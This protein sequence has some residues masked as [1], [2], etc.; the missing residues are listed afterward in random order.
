MLKFI[1]VIYYM[2][3]EVNMIK[4]KNNNLKIILLCTMIITFS[5]LQHISSDNITNLEDPVSEKKDNLNHSDIDSIEQTNSD[6]T[7]YES[8][9]D[10][11]EGEEEQIS[12]SD[13]FELIEDNEISHV[14]D[15][16]LF[17]ND[18]EE[19]KSNDETNQE[20]IKNNYS[21]IVGDGSEASPF[22]VSTSD[23]LKNAITES[24]SPNDTKHIKF[25]ANIIEKQENIKISHNT[26]IDGGGFSLIRNYKN[27]DSTYLF[28]NTP[29][30]T[31]AFKNLT[32]GGN[33]VDTQRST[34]Y[35]IVRVDSND[36]TVIA[37][38]INY[39]SNYGAQPF[40]STSYLNNTKVI[41]KGSNYFHLTGE[42]IGEFAQNITHLV[43]SQDS[44]TII[45]NPTLDTGFDSS[46]FFYEL[47]SLEIEDNATL[48]IVTA[49]YYFI[50]LDVDVKSLQINIGQNSRLKI[51]M[52]HS[53]ITYFRSYELGHFNMNVGENA[54]FDISVSGSGLDY[55]N[56]TINSIDPYYIKIEHT[57]YKK[58]P[59][60]TDTNNVL[61]IINNSN[62]NANYFINMLKQGVQEESFIE[63]DQGSDGTIFSAI[64]RKNM[65]DNS[66]SAAIFTK[67]PEVN[68]SQSGSDVSDNISDM[69][70]DIES[71]INEEDFSNYQVKVSLSELDI[72]L[73]EDSVFPS[74]ESSKE[75]NKI[76]EDELIHIEPDEMN[77]EH[78]KYK[79]V[80]ANNY[81]IYIKLDQIINIGQFKF[82]SKWVKTEINV[83]EYVSV[84]MLNS[85]RTF[86]SINS[87]EFVDKNE[88]P[89][90]FI[91]QGNVPLIT[92]L[93]YATRNSISS[94]EIDLVDSKE[95][96]SRSLNSHKKAVTSFDQLLL[97]KSNGKLMLNFVDQDTLKSYPILPRD[98]TK[99]NEY[100]NKENQFKLSP[101]WDSSENSVSFRVHGNYLGDTYKERNV[102][103]S[104]KLN[105]EKENK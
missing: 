19:S 86:R 37:D 49:K 105:Y 25:T 78:I 17:E 3:G 81:Y 16:E 46:N 28:T 5:T 90:V 56:P 73:L 31:I 67:F 84:K 68:I 62:K 100:Q 55:M 80:L 70:L 15:N 45:D 85:N 47:K 65:Q 42:R 40:Y 1:L 91:N 4:N 99:K 66:Y 61:K 64:S 27:A 97:K 26:I 72:N 101:F 7:Y 32:F 69:Y 41:L 74:Y 75:K 79:N 92:S 36:V 48:D 22:L 83:D 44:N 95:F 71:N 43:V 51:S 6:E 2:R 9:T 38:S 82:H 59:F 98:G 63:A 12:N 88:E 58:S 11:Q 77:F 96:E 94:T 30:I 20:I 24:F 76:I 29:K 60:Y 13:S 54:I 104:I 14:D 53:G 89:L 21:K 102:S 8:L 93:D 33:T 23:E 103:Y 52:V 35:G 10:Q 87:G 50:W 39:I 34:F 18:I 57:N